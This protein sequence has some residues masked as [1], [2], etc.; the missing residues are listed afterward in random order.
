M[1]YIEENHTYNRK[2]CILYFNFVWHAFINN[3]PDFLQGVDDI[4]VRE[5]PRV[6][7]LCD[8]PKYSREEVLMPPILVV[9]AGREIFVV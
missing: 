5:I 8:P 1:S 9:G 4:L 2:N 3:V 7:L 6:F